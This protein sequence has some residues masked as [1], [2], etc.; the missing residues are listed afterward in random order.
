MTGFCSEMTGWRLISGFSLQEE[1]SREKPEMTG[2]P[3]SVL[4]PGEAPLDIS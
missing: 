4:P 3:S 2:Y 1:R